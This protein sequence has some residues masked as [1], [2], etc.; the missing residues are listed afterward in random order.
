MEKLK[1]ETLQK[2]CK[3][4]NIV[5]SVH[6]LERMQEREISK[7]DVLN[8]IMN[9]KI[10]EDYPKAFPYPACLILGIDS[11]KRSLHVVCGSKGTIVKIITAYY[12]NEEKFTQSGETRK[13][14]K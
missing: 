14:S 11:S 8:V 12:P 3:N 7:S 6:A 1:I 2:L 5:W 9:G 10:I 4:S 13:E